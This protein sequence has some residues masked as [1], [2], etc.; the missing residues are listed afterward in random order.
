MENGTKT[1][2]KSPWITPAHYRKEDGSSAIK[3]FTSRWN[4]SYLPPSLRY[5]APQTSPSDVSS[6]QA[7]SVNLRPFP[8]PPHP[9]HTFSHFPARENFAR[10]P[11]G[12]G[13]LS[14]A[15]L[16]GKKENFCFLFATHQ[17]FFL[18]FKVSKLRGVFFFAHS[19]HVPMEEN[20]ELV[21][22]FAAR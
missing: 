10:I 15:W 9:H 21:C 7:S 16:R 22:L 3:L 8:F 5:N 18:S 4:V 14:S 12:E 1:A 11:Q 19:P 17:D 6:W 13:F 2:E 20:E